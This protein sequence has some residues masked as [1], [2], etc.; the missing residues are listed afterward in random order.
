MRA[1]LPALA[2]LVL[3]A[4]PACVIHVSGSDWHWGGHSYHPVHGSGVATT[5]ERDVEAFR[6]LTLAAPAEVDVRLGEP[7]SVSV[8]CDD[9]LVEHVRTR[10]EDGT[11]VIDL[12][13]GDDYAFHRS[14]HVTVIAP[15]LEGVQVSG[16]GDVSVAGVTGDAF[17]VHV[18]GSGDVRATGTVRFLDASV[19]GSGDLELFGLRAERV[20]ARVSGSGDVD[21]S[22]SLELDA[23]VSGSG[24]VRYRGEPEVCVTNVS[25]SGTIE[26]D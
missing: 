20:R 18:S 7:R 21:V 8:R 15:E 25:G 2:C 24:D 13:P 12:E 23:Q 10:V 11:L 22:A 4:A 3:V 16:S 17:Y 19:S 14:L 9:N 6:R 26:S 5:Q 1:S